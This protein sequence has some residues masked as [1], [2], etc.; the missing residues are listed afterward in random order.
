[1]RP[2]SSPIAGLLSPIYG[3]LLPLVRLLLILMPLS[4]LAQQGPSNINFNE[5]TPETLA[6]TVYALDSTA[7]AV[8]LFDLGQVKFEEGSYT[9]GLGVIFEKHTRIHLLN[10]KAF[11]LATIVLSYAR[12]NSANPVID[13]FKGATYNLEEGKVV[14]VKLDKTS[15][16][17]E[18]DGDI[19]REKIVF[20]DVKEG[21]VIDYSF[22]IVYPGIGY[23]PTWNFQGNFP[24]LWSEYDITIP[25]PFNYVLDM[26]GNQ[27]FV[28]DTSFLSYIHLDMAFPGTAFGPVYRGTWSGD[29]VRRIWTMKDIPALDKKEPYTTTLKNHISKIEFQLS[30]IH[31]DGYNRTIIANWDDLTNE[32]MKKEDF[33]VPLTDRNNW[34]KD[35][36]KMIPG[37]D[38][39]PPE[40]MHS[41]F[42][43]V[44]DSLTCTEVESMYLSQP[45]KKTWEERKGNVA[46]INLL[47]TALYK[48]LGY[49]VSPV[50]LST[51]S[52][53]YAMESYPLLKDYNYTIARLKINGQSWLLDASRR[54]TGFGQLPEHCYNGAGRT[55]DP[56]HEKVLLSPDSLMETRRTVVELI[57]NDST[58]Y[59]G[60]IHHSAGSFESMELRTRVRRTKPEDFF[61]SL[62]KTMAA[63]KTMLSAGFDS[64]N[65]LDKTVGWHYDMKYKFTTPKVFFNP[66]MHERINTNPFNSPIRHYPVEM[67][68]CEDYSYW[69]NMEIPRGYVVDELPK[70]QRVSL[71]D[72][73]GVFEYR[74]ESDGKTIHVY[75]HLNIKKTH[76]TVAEYL[77]LRDFFSLISTTEKQEIVFKRIN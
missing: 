67:P 45:L 32:L 38:K 25:G 43:Y 73:S 20:P 2:A 30:A 36:L 26:Q 65:D 42:N 23:I 74:I 31:M 1:M 12:K 51:R 27:P 14:A 56:D 75:Y 19:I 8:I 18:E 10:R 41:I 21:S 66:I 60:S 22:R 13:N 48:H 63:Y 61:E 71:E 16:F 76:F 49:N 34:M 77:G 55:I 5:P 35:A 24:E 3:L 9:H 62:R 11:G 7:N 64:L 70:S 50:I 37:A 54:Y 58:G 57:N 17:K 33:G 46:D 4:G 39:T 47:L 44:R 53:G 52:H 72:G 59:A 6:P 68:F 29:A 40:A 15:I 28:R 69:L